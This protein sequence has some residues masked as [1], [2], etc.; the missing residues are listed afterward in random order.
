[1]FSS[2]FDTT[3]SAVTTLNPWIAAGVSITPSPSA[4]LPSSTS[5]STTSTTPPTETQ[6]G[7]PFDCV[8]WHTVESG[9][10]C[11]FIS[12]EY[13]IS[14]DDFYKWNPGVDSGCSALWLGYAVCVAV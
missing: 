8:K 4:T 10:G 1:M 14:L 3:I 11:Q 6:P 13:G 7:A 2:L 9:D 5:T 12:N